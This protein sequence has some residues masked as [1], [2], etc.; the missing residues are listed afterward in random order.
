MTET[1]ATQ[2]HWTIIA[3]DQEGDTK[4]LIE[5]EH[6]HLD[7][8]LR[9]GVRELIGQHANPSDYDLLIA[10]TVQENLHR[11]LVDAGL[12]DHSEVLIVPKDVSRG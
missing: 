11:T 10:G 1:T 5:N 4:S 9:E 7:Q 6:V 3:A 2:H 12:H 8:L